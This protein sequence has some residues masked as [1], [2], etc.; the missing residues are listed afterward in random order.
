MSQVLLIKMREF[1]CN[2]KAVACRAYGNKFYNA[3]N[4]HKALLKYNESLCLAVPGSE[5]VG[6]AYAN[7][8]AVYLEMKLFD[9]C[10]ENIEMAKRN[11]YPLHDFE[12]LKKREEKC[13]ASTKTETK[14]AG[15]FLKLSHP[16]NKKVPF[17]IENLEAKEDPKYGRYIVTNKSLR[18]GDII[19]IEKPF[20]SVLLSQSNFGEIPESNIFQRCTNCLKDNALDLIPCS[21]CCTGL[22]SNY[23]HRFPFTISFQQCSVH[24]SALMLPLGDSIV[25]SV[26]L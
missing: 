6:L 23:F 11:N 2:E 3:R 25:L 9:R 24:A 7:R 12:I 4:F 8:S 1:K 21:F 18:V 17:V 10:W 14:T 5:N 26:Q 19:A 20:G 15:N 13:Q 16:A 22:I